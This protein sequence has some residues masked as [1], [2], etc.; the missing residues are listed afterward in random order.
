MIVTILSLLL[1]LSALANFWLIR[2]NTR[3]KALQQSSDTIDSLVEVVKHRGCDCEPAFYLGRLQRQNQVVRSVA[4]R[5]DELRALVSKEVQQQLDIVNQSLL[6]EL[7]TRE[8][9]EKLLREYRGSSPRFSTFLQECYPQLSFNDTRLLTLIR[10]NCS[11]REIGDLLHISQNSVK[12]AQY[13]LRK[14]MGVESVQDLESH[15]H[16]DQAPLP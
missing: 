1:G 16:R 15:Y 7:N 4:E 14:K 6:E 13:R 5:L 10:M 8:D 9:W 12:K 11:A 2:Q 3:T